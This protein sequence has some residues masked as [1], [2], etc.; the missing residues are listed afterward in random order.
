M[1]SIIVI[2]IV[3]KMNIEKT[4]INE[5]NYLNLVKELD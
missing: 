4:L 5:T 3:I 2:K 1:A